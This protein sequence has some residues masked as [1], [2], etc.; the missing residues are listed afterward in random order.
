MKSI[1]ASIIIGEMF[2][3]IIGKFVLKSN[4]SVTKHVRICDWYSISGVYIF[5]SDPTNVGLS[6]W[7]I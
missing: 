6:R 1:K 3:S 4:Y 2:K 5:N 7:L